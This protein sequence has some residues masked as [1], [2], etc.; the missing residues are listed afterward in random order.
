METDPEQV[1]Q[2]IVSSA[3]RIAQ[4]DV[5]L[6]V[7]PPDEN[8]SLTLMAGYD[9]ARGRYLEQMQLDARS[10]PALVSALRM[11]RIRRLNTNTT[12][13]DVPGLARILNL[14][15]IGNLLFVPNLSPDGQSISC[16][17]FMSLASTRDWSPEEQSFLSNFGRLLVYFLQR[18]HEVSGLRDELTQVRQ[19]ARTAQDQ[20]QL[21]LEDRRKLQDQLVVARDENQRSR[22]QLEGMAK[23]LSDQIASQE[24]IDR[25]QADV[26]QLR[27]ENQLLQEDNSRLQQ[28]LS[29]S[30]AVPLEKDQASEGELRMALEQV[31]FL[32]SMLTEADQKITTLKVEQVNASPFK[33]QIDDISAIAKELRQPLSSLVSYVDFLLS[34]SVGILGVTQRKYLERIK[35]STERMTRLVDDLLQVTLQDSHLIQY[36]LGEVNLSMILQS[37]ISEAG[38]NLRQKNITLHM[39][40]GE[41]PLFVYT[42]QLTLRSALAGL[43]ANATTA[44]PSGGSVNLN[45][46]VQSSEGEEDYVLVQIADSGGGIAPQDLPRVFSP[47]DVDLRIAGLGDGGADLSGIKTTIEAMGGRTWVDSEPGMGATFSVLLPVSAR[48]ITKLGS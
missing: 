45:A 4:A 22:T 6:L 19:S 18:S 3:A 24:K 16:L 12:S 28:S 7:N 17:V 13:L 25:L 27:G 20:V 44:S 2:I 29:R 33:R 43:L 10:L 42:D 48:V 14:D 39:D 31:A 40:L 21:A 11:G 46:R 34:E 26:A 9:L 15:S 32:Q 30:L 23:I 38:Q 36:D 5:C 41:K 1:L 35:V 37:A 47:P 8:G